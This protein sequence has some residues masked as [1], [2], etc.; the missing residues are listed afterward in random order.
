MVIGVIATMT[1]PSLM[2][3]VQNA[4]WKAGYKKAYSTIANLIAM[5][6]TSGD[7]PVRTTETNAL[8]IFDAMAR[9]LSVKEFAY[10]KVNTREAFPATSYSNGVQYVV[11][12]GDKTNV[13]KTIGAEDGAIK[14]TYTPQQPS[15][16]DTPWIITEDGM[17]YAIAWGT[18]GSRSCASKAEIN[19]VVV[20]ENGSIGSIMSKACFVVLVDVNGLSK[21]PNL[22]EPQAIMSENRGIQALTGD[23][24]YIFIGNDGATAGPKKY[25]FTGRLMGD[26]K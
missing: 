13:V 26:T 17:A 16:V 11:K 25:T 22:I 7:L 18:G 3:G 15:K 14:F 9:N 10:G 21:M 8:L 19:N 4:Q 12:E 23:Q 1:I 20:E 5:L 24:Y 2:R 6:K